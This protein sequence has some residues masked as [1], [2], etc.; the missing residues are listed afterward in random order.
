M[1]EWPLDQSLNFAAL[2][3][4]LAVEGLGG[5][6]ATP[7]WGDIADWWH[8]TRAEGTADVVARYGFLTDLVAEAPTP[9]ARRGA[10]TFPFAEYTRST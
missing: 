3:A 10:T 5:A 2:G 7:G 1:R 8:R 9:R 4:A 6:L